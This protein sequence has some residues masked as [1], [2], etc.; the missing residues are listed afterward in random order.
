MEFRGYGPTPKN[1]IH[2]VPDEETRLHKK[3]EAKFG[4]DYNKIFNQESTVGERGL[5]NLTAFS[6]KEDWLILRDVND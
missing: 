5:Y 2:D 4:D 1:Q 6:W 3:L